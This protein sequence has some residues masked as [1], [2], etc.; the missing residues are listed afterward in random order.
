[1]AN[2]KAA[3]G[4]KAELLGEV[5]ARFIKASP[6][7]VMARG[8]LENALSADGLDELFAA[9]AE[10]QYVRELLF[11]ALVNLMSLVV[12]RIRPS[13]HAAY[14]AIKDD[15]SVSVTAVYDKLDRF[16][17]GLAAALTEH[18]HER[19][20]PV[21]EAM[22][23]QFEP[24]VP[25]YRL[26]ILDG[27]HLAATERRLKV[28]RGSKAGP[29]PGH[30]LVVF[31]PALKLITNVIPCEDGHAQERSLTSAILDLVRPR[32]VWL[33][34]RNF[35]T[36][37]LI[38]GI[39]DKDAYFI[40]RQHA[41]LSW[42][43]AGPLRK[44]GRVEGGTV[45]EQEVLVWE[46]DRAGR[47]LHV[48]RITINLKTPTR[49]GESE[50]H[51][52]TTL[53]EEVAPANRIAAL[54]R[55]RWNIET[56][57]QEL[58]ATLSGEIDTLGYPKAA[59]FAFCLALAA[60]NILSTVKAALRAKHGHERVRAEVSGYYI[61]DEVRCTYRGMMIAIEEPHWESFQTM[62]PRQLGATLV[63]LAGHVNLAAFRSHPR[64]PKKPV[65]KRTRF[66]KHTH[67]S[68]AR[69]LADAASKRTP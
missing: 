38:F 51:V 23:G 31:D 36:T 17:P 69:L 60:Y 2:D 16:E 32:D 65:P 40:T 41:G 8:V 26:R 50:V 54:Y 39:A 62:T 11:S 28:L 1:M 18:T 55:T 64:G 56:A 35:C 66:A 29:L 9:K 52:L 12:F 57:F 59:L 5:F 19:L 45:S 47:T 48:R 61:A 43:P 13:V 68:T 10:R 20:A 30:C 6:I 67:V 3:L 49:D 63:A 25:G 21:V 58:A 15:V 42:E 34:D 53:P 22:G 37:R 44:R 4:S 27:N 7:S 46:G 24:P 14:Q 33:D